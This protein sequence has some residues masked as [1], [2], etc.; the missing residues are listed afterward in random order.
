MSLWGM[1][2]GAALSGAAKFTNG[3]A[4]FIDGAN[5][6]HT[7]FTTDSLEAGDCV[8]GADGLLYR[9]KAVA[10]QTAAT[11]D[12]VYEGTTADNQTVLRVKLP[13][14]IKITND[15]GTGMSLQDLGVFGINKA[16]FQSNFKNRRTKCQ[17][18]E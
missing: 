17:C 2:D 12:R 5:G 13:R 1:N 10:S 8:I 3:A 14:H 11:L 9:I 4:T 15:D 16:E 7:T 18:G 6:S